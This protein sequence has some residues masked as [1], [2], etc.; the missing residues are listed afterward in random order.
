M[1]ISEKVNVSAEFDTGDFTGKFKVNFNGKGYSSWDN[2]IQKQY[3]LSFDDFKIL[4]LLI[5]STVEKYLNS[6]ENK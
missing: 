6:K 5:C 2:C 1:I 3:N 4:E